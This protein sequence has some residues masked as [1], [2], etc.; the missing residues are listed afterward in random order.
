[1]RISSIVL[2]VAV[3][4]LPIVVLADAN[5]TTYTGSDGNEYKTCVSEAYVTNETHITTVTETP[6]PSSGI[7]DISHSEE[8]LKHVGKW[9]ESEEKISSLEKKI[10]Q[11]ENQLENKTE[12][13]EQLENRTE[14]IENKTTNIQAQVDYLS[15]IVSKLQNLVHN[16]I[17]FIKG[18]K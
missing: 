10:E 4:L 18:I 13:I 3:L 9:D 6:L 5:C 7:V 12:E 17:S 14:S 16:I 2:L 15:I 8:Y 1:M 11:L